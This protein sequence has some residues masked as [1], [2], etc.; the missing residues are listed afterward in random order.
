MVRIYRS[1]H[2]PG[3]KGSEIRID[4]GERVRVIEAPHNPSMVGMEAV[5]VSDGLVTHHEAPGNK[6]CL[7]VIFD[8]EK[9]MFAVYADY[10]L[11]VSMLTP[12]NAKE[13]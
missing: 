7:E 1:R 5:V 10:L 11:P 13:S 12:S 2:T 6:L 9:E 8:G 3:V 4:K